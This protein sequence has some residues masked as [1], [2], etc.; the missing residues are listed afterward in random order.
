MSDLLLPGRVA[1]ELEIEGAF[2]GDPTCEAASVGTYADSNRRYVYCAIAKD[3]FPLAGG[4]GLALAAASFCFGA[5][6]TCPVWM[7]AHDGRLKEIEA[8]LE[9]RAN[10]RATRRQIASGLRVDDRGL[11]PERTTAPHSE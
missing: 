7:R 1:R 8:N 3:H 10:D 4:E 2:K 9:R 5:Y 6:K 11:D